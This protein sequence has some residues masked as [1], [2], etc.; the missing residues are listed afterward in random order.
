MTSGRCP[1]DA[2]EG[3]VGIMSIRLLRGEFHPFFLGQDY[4]G[5]LQAIL[6]AP[7]MLIAGKTPMAL[8]LAAT[9]EGIA[10]LWFWRKLFERWTLSAAFP[11]FAL[12]LAFGNEFLSVWTLKSRGGIELLLLGS[13]LLWIAAEI[14]A[15][16]RSF[17]EQWRRFAAAGVVFGVAWWSSQLIAFFFVP[18]AVA[19]FVPAGNRQRMRE[20]WSLAGA[21]LFVVFGVAGVL[22]V[23]RGTVSYTSGL[24]ALLYGARWYLVGVFAVGLAMAVWGVRARL[25][26]LWPVAAGVGAVLGYLPALAA[27]FGK[28]VLY[29]T[30][31]LQPPYRWLITLA[32]LFF[33]AGASLLG[34]AGPMFSGIGVPAWVVVLVPCVVLLAVVS[35][36]L[37]VARAWKRQEAEDALAETVLL[38]GTMGALVLLALVLLPLSRVPHYAV[39]L[40]FFLFG[41]IACFVGR[42]WASK[43]AGRAGRAM[44]AAAVAVLLLFAAVNTHS[45]L[46][47]DAVAVEPI[48]MVRRD[49]RAVIDFLLKRGITVGATSFTGC[50]DGYWEAYRISMSS[51][52]RVRLHP[53]LHMPRVDDYREALRQADTIAVV[54]H[55]LGDE[56]ET[57]RAAGMAFER[58]EVGGLE[59]IW[60]FDKQR[61]DELGLISY[62]RTL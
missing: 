49:D 45:V 12:L 25:L 21:A 60:G 23:L 11:F 48:T 51:G 41:V 46:K 33:E 8:R 34:L 61:A 5:A 16:A 47:A 22:L 42:L 9:A 19:L 39:F 20:G 40:V 37:V 14:T 58:T 1:L 10:V 32:S 44:R 56:A 31:S 53:V 57:L 4:M 24:S 62:A 27:I 35:T 2:D 6:P 30:T 38:G 54:G 59:V 52:E 43:E 50:I 28:P 29:N 3:I 7:F 26:P 15:D 55:S 18:L 36:L 13:A 17:R